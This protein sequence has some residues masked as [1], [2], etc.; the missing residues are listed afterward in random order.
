MRMSKYLFSVTGGCVSNQKTNQAKAMKWG[1]AA[2]PSTERSWA[3]CYQALW[4]LLGRFLGRLQEVGGTAGGS[5]CPANQ[6]FA[7]LRNH[8]L[9]PHSL[10]I[11]KI[12]IQ[13]DQIHYAVVRQR[14][15]QHREIPC[16]SMKFTG[17]VLQIHLLGGLPVRKKHPVCNIYAMMIMI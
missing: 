17:L 4:S 12:Q 1:W 2:T 5:D 15:I 3:E 11:Y 8:H 9:H 13:N 16:N 14:A 10:Q 7:H 6:P